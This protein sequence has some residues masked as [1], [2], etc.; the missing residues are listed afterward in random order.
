MFALPR[1]NDDFCPSIEGKK[2]VVKKENSRK[3]NEGEGPLEKAKKR[4]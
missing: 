4:K 2:N 3:Q 1:S